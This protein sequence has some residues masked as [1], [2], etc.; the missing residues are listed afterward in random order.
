MKK[1]K[2]ISCALC[3]S[4]IGNINAFAIDSLKSINSSSTL[5]I[6]IAMFD[7]ALIIGIM[8]YV[9]TK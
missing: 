7:I 3:M 8:V 1:I 6:S 9:K 2:L 5:L 4:F